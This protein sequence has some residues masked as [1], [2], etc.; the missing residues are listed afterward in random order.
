VLG[1]EGRHQLQSARDFA[2]EAAHL[3][4]VTRSE[5]FRSA[6]RCLENLFGSDN[7]PGGYAWLHYAWLLTCESGRRPDALA[8][9]TRVLQR[10]TPE[11]L[12]PI[13]GNL[14]V[15]LCS[16]QEPDPS[17]YAY[18]LRLASAGGNEAAL[19]AIG[20][21]GRLGRHDDARAIAL[22]A[23]RQS[24]LFVLPILADPRT[25][26]VRPI[27]VE[28]LKDATAAARHR[29]E[30]SLGEWTVLSQKVQDAERVSGIS[31]SLPSGLR[32]EHVALRGALARARLLGAG[33]MAEHAACQARSL[34]HAA[35][36]ALDDLRRHRNEEVAKARSL[37]DRL[38]TG[39]DEAL[40]DARRTEERQ[41]ERARAALKEASRRGEADGCM[42]GAGMGCGGFALYLMISFVLAGRGIS[43]GL[44]TPFGV[45]AIMVCSVPVAL[46]LFAQ[47][48][49]GMRRAAMEAEFRA[50]EREARQDYEA[51]AARVESS[52]RGHHGRLRDELQT[53][54]AALAKVDSANEIL[55]NMAQAA[56]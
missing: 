42:P 39:R 16:E 35:G 13:A 4:G 17:M 49:A 52:F 33:A 18:A 11:S 45:F 31:L 1:D 12:M 37:L 23:L 15:R 51:E 3:P 40:A 32:D 28:A 14:H 6:I 5:T 10:G 30:A 54:E 44:N 50:V 55:A 56:A 43:A 22:A 41:L 24:P 47:L 9:V 36:N 20:L 2:T 25:A 48:A 38:A 46:A 26:P 7:P 53:A 29:A 8:A 34:S 21:A 27:L 19:D